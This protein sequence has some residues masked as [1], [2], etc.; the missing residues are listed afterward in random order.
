ML[1]KNPRI[2]GGGSQGAVETPGDSRPCRDDQ[3]LE[4]LVE[5]EVVLFHPRLKRVHILNNTA[6]VVWRLCDGIR[7]KAQLCEDV[8]ILFGADLSIVKRDV[9]EVLDQFRREELIQK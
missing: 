6:A 2:D 7:T 8:A 5:G 4:Y 3:V 9:P 1:S